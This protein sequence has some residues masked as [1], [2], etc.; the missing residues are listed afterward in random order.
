MGKL[1]SL[2]L[3][4]SVSLVLAEEPVV[5]IL[6]NGLTVVT[7]E[8]H[9]APVVASVISYRV[10]G[11][12]ETGNDIGLSHF[13]EHQ[14]FKGTPDMPEGRFWQIVQRDGGSANAFTTEDITCFYL[15]LPSGRLEDALSIESDRMVNCL[16]DS[17]GIV[18]ERNVVHEE[19]RMRTADDP[20][21]ALMEALLETAYTRHPYGRPVIGYD[22]NILAYNHTN[23]RA[24]YET[25]Y[26]PSNAVLSVVGDFDTQE[27]LG[28]IQEY[29]GDIPAG[30]VPEEH[31][32]TEPEQT[33]A[34]LVEVEHASN[35]PR[36]IMSFHACSGSDPANP[37]MEI[38]SSYLSGGRTGR[39][40]QLLVETGLV[41]GAEAWNDGGID[42]G[43]FSIDVT[44]N[45]PEDGGPAIEE[46]QEMVWNE[47]E[48]LAENGIS[49]ADLEQLKNRYRAQDVLRDASP[50]GLA[51][52]YSLSTT[53]FSDPMHSTEQLELIEQ[54]TPEDIKSAADCFRRNGV[55]VATLIP[56]GGRSMGNAG[57]QAL[58][59]DVTEPS[60]V[61]YDGLEI[62][63]DFMALPST[64]IAR[65]VE[66]F[67]LANGLVL[68]VK[69]DHTFPVAS[70]SFSVPMG[71]LMYNS[72]FNGLGSITVET[73]LHGTPE[74]EYTE[75][76]KRL[77][78]EGSSL[79][80]YSGVKSSS[81]AVTVLSEDIETAFT[82]V[83]DLLL[84]PAFRQSDFDRVMT[85]N[86]TD[87]AASAERTGSV[88]YDSLMFITAGSPAD[89]R[90]PSTESLDRITIEKVTEYYDLCCRPE[91]TVIT[92]VGDVDPEA[93]FNM[94]ENYFADW[95]N[96]EE[97]LPELQIPAFTTS[98]GDTVVTFMEGRTQS[99]VMIATQAPG[100]NMP[101]YP[102]FQ[103][104]NTILGS[105]IGSR[106]GHSVRD[107]QGLA[108]GVGSWTM[109]MDSTGVFMAYLAT[110]TDYVP[111]ATVSVI[112]EMEKI[113]TEN[114]QDIELRLAQA[115]SVGRQALS[116]MSY[117]SLAGKLTSLQAE[118]KPLDYNLLFLGKVLEL[119]PDDLREAAADYFIPG[120]WFVSIAGSITEEDAFP[121]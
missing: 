41:Y 108:Y 23:T 5:T 57:D 33:E 18:S 11:R 47:L 66:T 45:P 7:Q 2:I 110:L 58:P 30:N 52:N 32:P 43:L 27:L 53:M 10:G 17:S 79:R 44:M 46:I 116:S 3:V 107:E 48:N 77:E 95:N 91:G 61:N 72:E 80:F 39:F 87:L 54:L 102:A 24:Y 14:M 120:G 89:Y 51:M 25:Y 71:R 68:L 65:G 36:F 37:A 55:T 105:G 29:F 84:D 74:L 8:L 12:N 9:Y 106:L 94:T 121:E 70:V 97:P 76:H 111:Q 60:S 38:I 42:P 101:D 64:S 34:R 96:P 99:T 19:R 109:P 82:A 59:T 117:G 22:E 63:D 112:T 93:V 92:V 114:V 20:D 69:E 90:N 21:G 31:I 100:R 81:G 13:M 62:P 49:Q 26:C 118:G 50:V 83:A 104:M 40:D 15:I 16:L 67:E 86:Y 1:I 85:E 28:Q 98:R 88:A 119:T 78:N 103:V 4:V 115:N 73:M 35:L 113:S 75:F 56:T 6:E